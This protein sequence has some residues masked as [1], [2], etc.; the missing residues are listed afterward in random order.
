M[1]RVPSGFSTLLAAL[2]GQ[3]S[4][5]AC[6]VPGPVLASAVIS[7]EPGFHTPTAL[8]CGW[9]LPGP[10]ESGVYFPHLCLFIAAALM[11]PTLWFGLGGCPTKTAFRPLPAGK[12]D[13][14][15]VRYKAKSGQGLV[16]DE[17]DADGQKQELVCLKFLLHTGLYRELRMCSLGD[18]VRMDEEPERLRNLP[19]AASRFFG[20]A[21]I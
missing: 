5:V 15:G 13:E 18:L 3:G 8:L 20:G 14:S 4:C 6:R 16:Q 21:V 17:R 19:K 9:W 7:I 10:P 1:A 2:P 11:R 12:R